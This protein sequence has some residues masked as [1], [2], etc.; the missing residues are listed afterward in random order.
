MT[1]QIIESSKTNMDFRNSRRKIMLVLPAERLP[2]K[3]KGNSGAGPS[4]ISMPLLPKMTKE[5]M[6]QRTYISRR[7]AMPGD[8][9][10]STDRH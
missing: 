6:T 8:Q 9:G 3:T 7:V 1:V 10:P 5:Y 4:S 2:L